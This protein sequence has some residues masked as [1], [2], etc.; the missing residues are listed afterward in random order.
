[1]LH[2]H[3]GQVNALSFDP[4]F[5]GADLRLVSGGAD[6]TLRSWSVAASA[7]ANGAY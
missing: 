5:D 1:V 2:G 6:C 4:R 3:E 7:L